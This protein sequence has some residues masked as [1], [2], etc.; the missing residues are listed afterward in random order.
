M[1]ADVLVVERLA[2]GPLDAGVTRRF[3]GGRHVDTVAQERVDAHGADLGLH[4]QHNRQALAHDVHRFPSRVAAP[5]RQPSAA[6]LDRS[7]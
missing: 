6:R 3:V 1:E 4:Q 2:R 5:R 7:G